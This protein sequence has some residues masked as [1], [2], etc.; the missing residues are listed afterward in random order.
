[1]YGTDLLP[2]KDDLYLIKS[3]CTCSNEFQEFLS[4]YAPRTGNS[5]KNIT[6]LEAI[7]HNIFSEYHTL[8]ETLEHI[9]ENKKDSDKKNNKYNKYILARF[10][11]IEYIF[12]CVNADP[13]NENRYNEDN[14]NDLKR[15]GHLLYEFDGM[16]GMHDE[17]IWSFIPERYQI[18][19]NY[20]WNGI[21][22]WMI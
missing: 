17:Y 19:I 4:E 8:K 12:K 2:G 13:D 14:L 1:M 16:N 21:G 6:I 20:A 11:I 9:D 5:V 10:L 3:T 15:A 18:D 7:A 22:E